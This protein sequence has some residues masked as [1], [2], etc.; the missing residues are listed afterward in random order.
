M[1][2]R[3]RGQQRSKMKGQ[4]RLKAHANEQVK[5][6]GRDSRKKK[7]DSLVCTLQPLTHNQTLS[8]FF[9]QKLN[10]AFCTQ[11]FKYGQK[12]QPLIWV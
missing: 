1:I 2:G 3:W 11:D 12:L 6:G 10:L 4:E 9:L 5:H 7:I 8:F